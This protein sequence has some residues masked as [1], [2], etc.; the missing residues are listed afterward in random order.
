MKS[1]ADQFE[2]KIESGQM[3]EPIPIWQIKAKR[4]LIWILFGS[5]VFVGIASSAVAVW[6]I[7]DPQTV[8][9]EYQK[10]SFLDHFLSILPLFWICLSLAMGLAAVIVFVH[11]PRGYRYRAIVLVGAVILAFAAFGGAISAAG[12]SEKIERVAELMP[13]YR[14]VQMPHIQK[15][16]QPENGMMIG[17]VKVIEQQEFDLKDV[18]GVI[19][20][21]STIHC[22]QPL[23]R[24]ISPDGCVR[25]L[26]VPS[27]T[28]NYFDAEQIVPCPRG[29]RPPVFEMRV[30]GSVTP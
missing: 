26:G 12:F 7:T 19:W 20:H 13:G 16:T 15:F 23:D 28:E 17:Q 22:N 10:A 4:V 9:L 1:L 2:Q 11:A 5:F 24:V 8:I 27:S 29:I 14:F 18:R 25:V 6:F 21:V 30:K 3:P